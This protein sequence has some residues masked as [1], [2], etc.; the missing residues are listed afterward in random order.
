MQLV[1]NFCLNTACQVNVT[2]HAT[3]SRFILPRPKWPDT[4]FRRLALINERVHNRSQAQDVLQAMAEQV[5]AV[6]A[7]KELV[8]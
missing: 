1:S 7:E 2:T 8:K 3:T 4:L 6:K 5:A